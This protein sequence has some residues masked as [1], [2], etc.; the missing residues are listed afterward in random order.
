MRTILGN[1]VWIHVAQPDLVN[2]S[3]Q[4]AEQRILSLVYYIGTLQ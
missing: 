2:V 1:A 3:R 4:L